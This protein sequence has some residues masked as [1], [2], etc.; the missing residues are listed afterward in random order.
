[1][2]VTVETK[3]TDKVKLVNREVVLISQ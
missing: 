3:K 2:G 1:V